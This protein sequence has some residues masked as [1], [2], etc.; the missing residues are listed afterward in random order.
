MQISDDIQIQTTFTEQPLTA[1]DAPAETRRTRPAKASSRPAKKAS[2][3]KASSDADKAPS[4]KTAQPLGVLAQ[5]NAA[6]SR[7]VALAIGSTIGGFVPIA[8]YMLAHHEAPTRPV[9]WVLVAAALIFS[10]LSVYEWT[11]KAF[12]SRLKALGFVVLTEGIMLST[13]NDWLACAALALLVGINATATGAYLAT[14]R[15]QG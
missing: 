6:T 4:T 1:W 7:P 3:R 9:L 5:V 8:S 12:G 13:S 11:A 14:E 2:A 15:R 10:G